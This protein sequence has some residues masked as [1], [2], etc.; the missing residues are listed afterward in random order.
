MVFVFN[1][2]FI[3]FFATARRK[4]PKEAPPSAFFPLKITHVF[5]KRENSQAKACSNSPR[6]LT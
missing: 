5:L 6:F 3:L 2:F 4:E 1:F